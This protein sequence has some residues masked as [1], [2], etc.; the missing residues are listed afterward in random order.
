MDEGL[1][2]GEYTEY[3]YLTDDQQLDDRLVLNLYI[4]ATCPWMLDQTE[5]D[6]SMSLIGQIQIPAEN[7]TIHIDTDSEDMVAAFVGEQCV[8]LA[9]VRLNQ[10]T[11]PVTYMTIYGN[12]SHAGEALRFQLWHA[13]NGKVYILTPSEDIPFRA[14]E[15]YGC[16]GTPITLTVSD[17]QV[18][19]LTLQPG[20][21]WFSLYLKPTYSSDFTRLFCSSDAWTNGDIIKNPEEQYFA[22]Y[23]MNTSPIRWYGTLSTIQ[24]RSIFLAHVAQPIQLQIEGDRLDDEGRTLTLEQ[25]WN[26]LPYLLTEKQSLTDAL[27]DY[28]DDASEGDLIKSRDAFAVFSQDGK[29]EGN[30]TYM[31][32]G[33]GYMLLRKASENCNFTYYTYGQIAN[34]SPEDVEQHILPK[35]AATTMSVIASVDWENSWD[36]T[37]AAYIG[38]TLVGFCY[39]QLTTVEKQDTIFFLSI[40]DGA[41]GSNQWSDAD[42]QIRFVLFRNGEPIA[43]STEALSYE[44]DA[45][46]GTLRK[47]YRIAFR[48]IEDHQDKPYKIF[49]NQQIYIIRNENK[50]NILGIHY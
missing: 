5:L 8:A 25:G 12:D 36:Y 48:P 15:C 13:K 43:Q 34:V 32:P 47:P 23:R 16:E 22:E 33:Q 46:V 19:L 1:N 26:V 45:V 44:Q 37:L 30:L 3:I 17:R 11:K 4:K 24:Y 14:N 49:E 41:A 38:N 40:T 10:Q 7:G 39:P 35:P 9:P 27:A 21:N 20:W 50:Y 2:I 18:Q 31:Q 29:W 6:R 28:Y 42:G